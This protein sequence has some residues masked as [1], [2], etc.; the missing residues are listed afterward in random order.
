MAKKNGNDKPIEVTLWDA[1]NKLRGSVEPAEYKH[2]VL[3]LIFLKF[4]SDKFEQH[5]ACTM[6]AKSVPYPPCLTG[7]IQAG[8]HRDSFSALLARGTSPVNAGCPDAASGYVSQ[9]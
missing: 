1:A 9:Y 4:G 5:R 8:F 6:T 2:V 7:I 3:G